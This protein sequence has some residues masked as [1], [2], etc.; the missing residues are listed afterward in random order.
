MYKSI[1][2]K[3]L[4]FLKHQLIPFRNG[5]QNIYVNSSSKLVESKLTKQISNIVFLIFAVIIYIIYFMDDFGRHNF[6]DVIIDILLIFAALVILEI[7]HWFYAV[8]ERLD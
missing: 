5:D 2:P 8:F 6:S 3:L 1:K 4:T 7:I